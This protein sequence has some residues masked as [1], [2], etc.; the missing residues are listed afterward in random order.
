M[1]KI[2]AFKILALIIAL[3]MSIAIFAPGVMAANGNNGNGNGNGN[4]GNGNGNGN[5]NNSSSNSAAPNTDVNQ[6][7]YLK[8]SGSNFSKDGWSNVFYLGDSANATDPSVWHLVYS[9]NNFAAITNMQITFTNGEVFKWTSDMGPSTNGGGNNPGWVIVAPAGWQIAYVDKGNNNNSDS[10][11]VTKESGNIQFNIS[12]FHNGTADPDKPQP[13]DT[14]ILVKIEK[15]V[16]GVNIVDWA[17]TNNINISDLS[18]YMSFEL[19]AINTDESLG[20]LVANGTIGTDGKID[21]GSITNP[22]SYKVVEK[23]TTEG[24]KIFKTP[25]DL[26]IY[27]SAN[28]K[29][30]QFDSNAL[31]TIVNGYSSDYI[32]NLEYR[33]K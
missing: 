4:N 15:S 23:L 14:K 22:G 6:T 24:E 13:H 26:T 17:K 1:R 30:T 16:D 9:G 29:V 11:V 25:T 19:Y 32:K 31:Y 33:S 7:I 3:V 10:F 28:G 18:K 2:L 21:F 8:G 12:G 20:D 27:V 5:G